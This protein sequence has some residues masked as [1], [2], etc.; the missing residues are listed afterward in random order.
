[1][2]DTVHHR[3]VMKDSAR[4][5]LPFALGLFLFAGCASTSNAPT[6]PSGPTGSLRLTAGQIAGAWSLASIQP[7]GQKAQA[8]PAGAIYTLTLADGRISTRV[9]CN[10]CSGT[11]TLSG[12]TLNVAELMACTRAACPTR[13]F[14]SAYMPIL[15]GASTVVQSGTTLVLTSS[16]GVLTFTR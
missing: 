2:A 7:A 8:V 11:F 5:F 9:D 15:A 4:F 14:E 3:I 12:E 13:E 6:S 1:M 10:M 16:R